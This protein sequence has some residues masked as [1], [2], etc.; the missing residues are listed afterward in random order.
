MTQ[1]QITYEQTKDIQIS[2]IL[3]GAVCGGSS[4]RTITFEAQYQ[5][6]TGSVTLDRISGII[7][8]KN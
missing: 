6:Y 5:N 3:P 1:A 4:I 2:N 8:T 7:S